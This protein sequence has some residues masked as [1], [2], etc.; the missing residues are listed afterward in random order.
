MPQIEA[1]A[2]GSFPKRRGVVIALTLLSACQPGVGSEAVTRL[3]EP[4]PQILRAADGPPGA[5]P[6]SC[7]GRDVT[8]ALIETVT[9]QVMIQPPQV[10]ADGTVTSP[11]VFKT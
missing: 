5:A 6:D 8:P 2:A 9:E 10:T 11:A 3:L 4:A 1:R 7:W